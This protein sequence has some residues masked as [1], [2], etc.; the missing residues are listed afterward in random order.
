MAITFLVRGAVCDG[1]PGV[2]ISFDERI[3]EIETN[4][5]SLGFDLAHLQR[6]NLL[7]TDYLHIERQEIEETGE[8]DLEGPVHPTRPCGRQR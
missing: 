7:A 5:L 3:S 2:L 8:Y 1:E 6:K 4:S